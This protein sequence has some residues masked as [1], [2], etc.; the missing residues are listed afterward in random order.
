MS[1]INHSLKLSEARER[2]PA[3]NPVEAMRQQ[4]QLEL[5]GAVKAADVQGIAAKLKDMALAGDLKAMKL[6]FQL[7]DAGKAP[8][9][10]INIEKAILEVQ[11]AVVQLQH[12]VAGTPALPHA[13]R[14]EENW[15]AYPDRYA[16]LLCEHG[17]PDGECPQCEASQ[18]NGRPERGQ[19]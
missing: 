12:T 3:V 10:T 2:T 15:T 9:Q 11:E 8:S 5:F 1:R 18:R 19:P 6:F 17:K 4:L 14:E 7:F 13:S 16:H